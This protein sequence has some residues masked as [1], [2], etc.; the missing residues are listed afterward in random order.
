MKDFSYIT[1]PTPEY[2]ESLYNEFAKDST[3]VDPEWKKF[4]E[5]FDFATLNYNGKKSGS[6]SADEFKVYNLIISYRKKGHLIAK[7]NRLN[8]EPTGTPPLPA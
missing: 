5:G 7:T 4:F 6:F 2:I 8:N 3:A 1:G